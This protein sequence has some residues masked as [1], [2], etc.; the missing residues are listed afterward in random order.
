MFWTL[1]NERHCFFITGLIF[2]PEIF[3][4]MQ[5]STGPRGPGAMNFGIAWN[6]VEEQLLHN[7]MKYF[8]GHWANQ[9]V[10]TNLSGESS[11]LSNLS[12]SAS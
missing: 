5:K 1:W 6:L 7:F 9:I 8:S 11:C 2:T 10:N 4:L 12:F 3:I